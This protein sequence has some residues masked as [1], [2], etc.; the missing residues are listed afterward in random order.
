LRFSIEHLLIG[1]FADHAIA[2]VECS[3]TFLII[4]GP[5]DFD[6]AGDRGRPAVIAVQFLREH[7]LK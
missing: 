4:H 7:L 3:Q 2:E 1:D 6:G 5:I